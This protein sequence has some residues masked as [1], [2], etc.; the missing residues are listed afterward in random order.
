MDRRRSR[1]IKI[2]CAARLGLAVLLLVGFL[3]NLAPL[4]PVSAGSTCTLEC[5]AGRAPHAAGSCMN[6]SCQAVLS[7]HKTG[8]AHRKIPAQDDK[9][10][11]FN[12]AVATK[13]V[14]RLS[15]N[16]APRPAKSDQATISAAAFVK[17]C[18]P[19]C[20]G[21]ASGFASSNRQRNS[22]TMAH[23]AR[24]RPPTDLH[25][26]DFGRHGAQTLAALCRQ[27]APRGPPVFFS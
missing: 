19:D 26:L 22:A 8:T 2:V 23:A 27:C 15:V 24:P 20:G 3:A 7:T 9:L 5:C 4:V 16:R 1:Q 17:P 6:G 25:L 18:Q 11:G 13:I 10:C 21:C 12:R 14:G